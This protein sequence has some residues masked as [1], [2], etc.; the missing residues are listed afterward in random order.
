MPQV[1]LEQYT[2][3]GKGRPLPLRIS[4]ER[5]EFESDEKRGHNLHAPVDLCN[6]FSLQ[7]KHL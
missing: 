4:A 7:L 1:R 3:L 2:V 5:N 6:E